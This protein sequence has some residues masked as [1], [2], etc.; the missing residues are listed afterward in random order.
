MHN[1]KNYWR[2][3]KTLVEKI[4]SLATMWIYSFGN[5]SHCNKLQITFRKHDRLIFI[6]LLYILH[7]NMLCQLKYRK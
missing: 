1:K 4:L 5:K 7:F 2:K 3:N 6:T